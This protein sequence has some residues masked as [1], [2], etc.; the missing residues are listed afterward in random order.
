MCSRLRP[1][2]F[3]QPQIICNQTLKV[4]HQAHQPHALNLRWFI[5]WSAQLFSALIIAWGI[6]GERVRKAAR[7]ARDRR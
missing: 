7:S 6:A 1:L 4:I 2:L 5:V 3:C